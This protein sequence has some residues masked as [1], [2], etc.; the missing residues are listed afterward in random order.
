MKKSLLYLFFLIAFSKQ[1]IGFDMRSYINQHQNQNLQVF[2]ENFPYSE[3]L[4]TVAFTDFSI[5]QE[6]RFFVWQQFQEGDGFLYYL[7]D[8]FLNQY[9]VTLNQLHDKISIG[10]AYL[11]PLKTLGNPSQPNLEGNPNFKRN[12]DEAYH[13]IGYYI[14]SKVAEKIEEGHRNKNFNI[15]DK[16][17]ISYLDRLK[18]KKVFVSFEESSGQKIIKNIQQG[19]FDY[20]WNRLILKTQPILC[21][22]GIFIW[23]LIGV[24]VVLMFTEIW[25]IVKVF[26]FL[27]SIMLLILKLSINCNTTPKNTVSTTPSFKQIPFRSFYPISQTENLVDIYQL[28]DNSGNV[29]GHSIWM[30]RPHIKAD[31][32]SFSPTQKFQSLKANK[33]IILATSG[34]YTTNNSGDVK[35][36]GFTVENGDLRNAVLLHDRQGLALFSNTGVRAINLKSNIRLPNGNTLESPFNSLLAYSKLLKW[37]KDNKA[38]V[39]QTHLLAYGDSILISPSK[40]PPQQRERRLLALFSDK[41][42]NVIHSI[43]DITSPY[44]L[45]LITQEIFNIIASRG[46]KVEGI[47]NL[48]T[49]A[50]NI[51]NIFDEN[52]SLLTDVIGPVNVS[53]ATNLV[54]YYK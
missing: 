17:N 46:L 35:P 37:C 8:N 45:A 48:D 21:K 39:F 3:Y 19:R 9:P 7:A 28:K 47:L 16:T 4:K 23:I 25:G 18:D 10:E 11:N 15:N 52:G 24:L 20:L 41:N 51:L 6:H 27:I 30:K 38:T 33:N 50:Y 14:L 1:A 49:G 34:G 31:Y 26:L 44:D 42:G 13:I 43:F 29:I 36:D 2:L 5:I 22:A 53:S 12:T 40:A 32:F 54:V